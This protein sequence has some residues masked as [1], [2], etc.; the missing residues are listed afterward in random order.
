MEGNK[1]TKSRRGWRTFA[2]V[3][4]PLALA[5]LW[6]A[7]I[8]QESFGA[9]VLGLLFTILFGVVALGVWLVKKR[10]KQMHDV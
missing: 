4:S 9:F 10:A 1:P 6:C 8:D 2:F 7:F 5:F 3:L